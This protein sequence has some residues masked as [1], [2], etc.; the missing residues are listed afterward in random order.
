MIAP[1]I[2]KRSATKIFAGLMEL[3][4]GF[5]S[6]LDCR[7]R[8]ARL[9]LRVEHHLHHPIL[10]SEYEHARMKAPLFDLGCDLGGRRAG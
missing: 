9:Q 5:A 7:G 2:E 3:L 8:N 6:A 1:S 10:H 4:L